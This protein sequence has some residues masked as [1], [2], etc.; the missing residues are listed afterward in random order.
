MV[1]VCACNVGRSFA[2]TTT[3]GLLVYSLDQSMTLDPFELDV[4]VTPERVRQ[5]VSDLEYLT[6][7]MLA[8]RLNEQAL[9]RHAVEHVPPAD[10][11]QLLQIL[12]VFDTDELATGRAS[13]RMK[14]FAPVILRDIWG[15]RIMQVH[16]Q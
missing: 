9:I 2:A 4:T 6:A 15:K 13:G 5:A 10:S 8:F 11:R 14:I 12:C 7:V 16:L 1:S 3:E